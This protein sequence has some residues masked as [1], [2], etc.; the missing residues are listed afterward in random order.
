MTLSEDHERDDATLVEEAKTGDADAFGQLYERYAADI[1]R[2]LYAHLADRLEAE[3]LTAEVFLRAWRYLPRYRER[4]FPFSSFLYRVARN[5]LIDHRRGLK[6][7]RQFQE[8]NLPPSFADGMGPDEDIA[9]RA[10][11]RVL[12]QALSQLRADYRDVLV[13]RFLN[14]CSV[15]EVAD[16]MR[17][18]H[19]AVRV[20]QHRALK[21]LREHL[22]PDF[23]R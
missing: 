16:I 15:A 6:R 12:H 3:D 4:G 13:L 8:R 19:G 22:P 5:M 9:R 14:G 18:S 2:F 17:R 20:L 1:Y 10:D 7:Q 11:R 23:G 21:A